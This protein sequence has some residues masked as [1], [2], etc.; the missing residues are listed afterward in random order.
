MDDPIQL[1]N[2]DL[3]DPIAILFFEWFH[4][5]FTS[6]QTHTLP[7]N[8]GQRTLSRVDEW[9]PTNGI[10]FSG[11]DET[12]PATVAQ[13]RLWP[14]P[15]RYSTTPQPHRYLPLT[16]LLLLSFWPQIFNVSVSIQVITARFFMKPKYVLKRRDLASPPSRAGAGVLAVA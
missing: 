6:N 2:N 5:A 11:H 1:N 14:P 12:F 13:P 4:L 7:T 3:D 16:A 9:R 8:E 15:L 10:R